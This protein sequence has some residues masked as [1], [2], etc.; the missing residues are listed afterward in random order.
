MSLDEDLEGALQRQRT[1]GP[2]ETGVVNLIAK[3]LGLKVGEVEL[4]VEMLRQIDILRGAIH[5]E[6]PWFR[7]RA[8]FPPQAVCNA[9]HAAA[10]ILLVTSLLGQAIQDGRSLQVLARLIVPPDRVAHICDGCEESMQCLAESLSTPQ[11]CWSGGRHGY[12]AMRP[13]RFIDA[14]RI[15]MEVA[16]PPGTCV[17]PLKRLT[18]PDTLKGVW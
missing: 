12:V 7:A 18:E 4:T 3:A 2:V 5:D 1:G 9:L 17:I 8:E 14:K 13:I 16:Q 10:R 11:A 6:Y 15:E